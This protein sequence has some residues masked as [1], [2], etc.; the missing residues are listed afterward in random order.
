MQSWRQDSV[1][2]YRDEDYDPE[3]AYIRELESE[4]L[5]EQALAE[6]SLQSDLDLAPAAVSEEEPFLSLEDDDAKRVEQVHEEQIRRTAMVMQALLLD[7]K[8]IIAGLCPQDQEALYKP[9]VCLEKCI[10]DLL[11]LV[12]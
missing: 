3:G 1:L 8:Q 12:R 7:Q 5:C 4:M 6:L 2:E 11:H 9:Q 10:D